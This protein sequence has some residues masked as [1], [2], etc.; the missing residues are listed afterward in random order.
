MAPIRARAVEGGNLQAMIASAAQRYGA[1]R[2]QRIDP[3][4]CHCKNGT[5]NCYGC[6]SVPI[7]NDLHRV[8]GRNGRDGRPGL[9]VDTP[10][11]AGSTGQSGRVTFH[12]RN[13][14]GSEQQYTTRFQLELVDF[15]VEDENGDGIF[16]PGEHAFICRIR[17]RNTGE[18]AHY[19]CLVDECY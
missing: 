16:E 4:S 2:H 13:H 8:A 19:R 5:G 7:H 15:D 9:C 6:Q 14:D 11:F 12:V 17:V 10:I 18:I 1:R 3:G